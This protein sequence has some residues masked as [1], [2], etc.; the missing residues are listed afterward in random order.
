MQRRPC[1]SRALCIRQ[2]VKPR[3]GRRCMG[4]AGMRNLYFFSLVHVGNFKSDAAPW[5]GACVSG[6]G[7]FH[8]HVHSTLL[9]TCCRVIGVF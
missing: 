9:C 5:V 2:G 7:F 8:V 1:R 6:A 4:S 3:Q